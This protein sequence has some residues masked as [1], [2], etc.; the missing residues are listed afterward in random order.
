MAGLGYKLFAAGE[1]LTAGNLQGYGIDQSVMVFASSAERTTELTAPSQGMVAFLSD[2]GTTWQYF[3]LY[4][5]STNP[6]GAKTAGWYPTGSQAIFYA[7][8]TRS[9]ATGT[10]YAPGSAGFT[11]SELWDQLSWRDAATNPDR[12]IPK[13]EGLYRATASVQWGANATGARN[14]SI[15]R[16]GLDLTT[17]YG[18]GATVRNFSM[19]GLAY[20]NGSTDYFNLAAFS[21]DSG[22]A[23]TVTV[24]VLVEYIRPSIV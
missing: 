2:S 22:G 9:T 16:N 6:G 5:A 20:M 4:N 24:Q 3:E 7:T 15:Q 8:A 12:I 23:L 17:F 11:Y 14:G 18:T 10:S 21:Q 1:I 13:S 19:T